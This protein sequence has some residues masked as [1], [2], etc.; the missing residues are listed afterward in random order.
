ME[1]E[2]CLPKFASEYDYVVHDCFVPLPDYV[3]D[4]DFDA[5]V[6]TQTFLSKRQDPDHFKQILDKY[7]F[8]RESIAFK[9]ALPQDDYT[10][11]AILDRWMV[12]WC[13]DVVFPVCV[14]DWDVLYPK[15]SQY[16]RFCQGYTGYISDHLIDRAKAVKPIPKRTIDVSYRAAS[17]S[18]E[19]GRLGLVKSE[20]GNR[21]SLRTDGT[22]LH[23]DISTK[24][25]DT[26]PGTKW[27]D[28]IGNSKCMLGV[29]SGSS[30]LDPEGEI[31]IAVYRHLQRNPRATFEE[32]EA[33]CFLGLDGKYEFMAISPRNL[34]CALFGTVQVLTPGPYGGFIHPEEH[35]LPLEP[36][37]SNFD[38]VLAR[39]KDHQ[40]LETVAH[41]CRNQILSFPELRYD[42]H[43]EDLIGK[44][45]QGTKFS[46]AQRASSLPLIKR[47]REEIRAIENTF[48]RKRRLS[49]KCR[50]FAVKM[51]A[52]RAKYFLM[53]LV[54]SK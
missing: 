6:L 49:K 35:F 23:L 15:Y 31:G 51:G 24:P 38:A 36:D 30:L 46:D 14:N 19:F 7:D 27:Y 47:H 52:R 9:I 12:D 50:E 3:K 29:N 42:N 39:I 22:G 43:V 20:I 41:A 16:G 34:E 4:I 37:M 33:A 13:V 54:K 45:R 17:L 28:F 8:V 26:I 32:V 40:H 11:S 25:S 44:I 2:L 21:F 1:K 48:W 10:C 53:N 5:I 18:P